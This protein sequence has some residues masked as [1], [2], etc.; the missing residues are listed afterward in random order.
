[1]FPN[2]IKMMESSKQRKD[3]FIKIRMLLT[4][5]NFGPSMNQLL[6]LFTKNEILNQC[7]AVSA[8]IK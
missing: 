8:A 3:L 6:T 4:G 5:K 2:E 1:M 7:Y